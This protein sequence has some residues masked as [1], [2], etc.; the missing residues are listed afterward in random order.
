M[1]ERDRCALVGLPFGEQVGVIDV[2][3][4]VENRHA[5]KSMGDALGHRPRNEGGVGRDALAIVLVHHIPLVDSDQG[6]GVADQ[7]ICGRK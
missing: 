1:A 4:S 5:D 2:E 7:R 3:K 6:Q